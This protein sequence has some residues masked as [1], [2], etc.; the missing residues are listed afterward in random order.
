[1]VRAERV[2]RSFIDI[3]GFVFGEDFIEPSLP[4]AL[5]FVPMATLEALVF[6]LE[7]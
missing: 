5:V 1:V 2:S 3:G 4:I 7:G 6:V